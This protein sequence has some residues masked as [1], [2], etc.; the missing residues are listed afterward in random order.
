MVVLDLPVACSSGPA[1]TVSSGMRL[2]TPVSENSPLRLGV[3]EVV[4][5][6]DSRDA[7]SCLLI[8]FLP[9]VVPAMPALPASDS[10]GALGREEVEEADGEA[11][12]LEPVVFFG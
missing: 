10:L 1:T 7:T 4:V 3:S 6:G 5:L 9:L 12:T 8:F 11:D 2:S